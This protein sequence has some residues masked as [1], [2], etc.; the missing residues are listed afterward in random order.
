MPSE[1]EIEAATN[2]A[3]AMQDDR[4][5]ASSLKEIVI[6]ALQA[7]EQER[8]EWR[9]IETAPKKNLFEC[10]IGRAASEDNIGAVHQCNYIEGDWVVVGM[11]S[12]FKNPTHWMP[13]PNPPIEEK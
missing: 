8:Q 1:R 6:A 10:L 3:Y 4:S 9:P 12:R 7:A 2:K 5:V 13:L 11:F